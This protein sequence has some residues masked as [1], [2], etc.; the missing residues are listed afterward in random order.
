MIKWMNKQK[1]LT[2][3]F[4][5]GISS[6]IVCYVMSYFTEVDFKQTDVLKFCGSIS[7]LVFFVSWMM[8]YQGER[9]S[10]I[11]EEIDDLQ[12]RAKKAKTKTELTILIKEYNDLRQKADNQGHYAQLNIIKGILET[13]KDY[14]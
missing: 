4:I 13:K 1:P 11:F 9:S 14:L 10:L 5:T 12:N 3:G 8:F 2:L 7:I 6:F